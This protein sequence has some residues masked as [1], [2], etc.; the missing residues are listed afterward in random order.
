MTEET[1]DQVDSYV[2][3]SIA[4]TVEIFCNL[5][6]A[7]KDLR[8]SVYMGRREPILRINAATVRRHARKLINE[9]MMM[10]Y[11]LKTKEEKDNHLKVVK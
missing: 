10:D 11:H 2:A 5:D 8:H 4:D 1:N 7:M 6:A 9:L 3:A